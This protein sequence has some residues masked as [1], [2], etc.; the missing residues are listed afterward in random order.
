LEHSVPTIIQEFLVSDEPVLTELSDY[1]L[2][3][4]TYLFKLMDKSLATIEEVKIIRIEK[5]LSSLDQS[6][7]IDSI[8]SNLSKQF[9]SKEILKKIALE[10]GKN[11]DFINNNRLINLFK[12]NVLEQL[13]KINRFR[14]LLPLF[15]GPFTG[16]IT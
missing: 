10:Q 11:I 1:F 3:N 8:Y 13:Y 16:T 15:L 12:A 6:K 9:S 4:K 14:Y 7:I 2:I 5:V